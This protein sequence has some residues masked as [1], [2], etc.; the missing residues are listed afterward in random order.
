MN[1]SYKKRQSFIISVSMFFVVMAAFIFSMNRTQTNAAS[2]GINA[3]Y[4]TQQ[5][6]RNYVA[7]NG[8]TM[9]DT[10]TFT[11]N[12]FTE[13]PYEPGRLSDSTEQSALSM[14]KQIRYIAGISDDISISAKYCEYA[15]AAAFVNYLNG[16]ASHNPNRPYSIG[17]TLYQ[18]A[19]EGASGSNNSWASWG[20][21]SLNETIVKSWMGNADTADISTLEE[22]RRLLNPLMKQT[23]FGVVSGLKGTFSSVYVADTNNTM[24]YESGIAWPAR[25]MPVEYFAENYPW[26]Y[27]VGHTVNAND[28]HVT[29]T[30]FRD[31]KTWRFSTASADGDFYVSNNS[32]GQTGCI[33]FRPTLNSLDDYRNGDSFQVTITGAGSVI[34]YNVDFFNLGLPKVTYT[35]SFNSDGGSSVSPIVVNELGTITPLPTPV[36]TNAQFLGWYTSPNGQGSK[37]TETTPISRNTTYYAYWGN[38]KALTGLSVVYNGL[39]YAGANVSDGLV[40]SANYSNGTSERVYGFSVS[41]RT[42]TTGTNRILVTY[43]GITETIY[44]VVGEATSEVP[45][46]A[47]GNNQVF[48]EIFFHPNGGT[49]L[50][51]QKISLAQGDEID[52]LPTVERANYRFKGWYTKASGGRKV[53][54]ST[55]P[56]GECVL[57]AQWVRITKPQKCAVPSFASNENGQLKVKI[58]AITGAEGYEI[59]Y[60]TNKDFSSNAKKVST[61]YTTKTIK[62]LQRGKIYY[63]RVR[64]YKVD[65]M[66]RKLYGKYSAARG[67][68]VA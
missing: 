46:P 63:V 55:I 65:S 29:L 62:N 27:S 56:N 18:T 8:A 21:R 2:Q 42:L 24:A 64:A 25:T 33:I 48:Y 59:S 5:E 6:I 20:S 61:Y 37:L 3:R 57:Y 11:A 45:D 23:G 10:F 30:R 19:L 54:K 22:R 66:G 58:D 51:Y 38:N 28:I 53:S 47:P 15:Q 34:S 67:V 39:K 16:Q 26:S 7:T 9:N 32:Y 1:L 31:Y 40:V 50:N 49:N 35:V 52:A 13:L 4:R 41:Q 12:P 17:N 43:S 36:K 68:K 44:V 60:S 14:L